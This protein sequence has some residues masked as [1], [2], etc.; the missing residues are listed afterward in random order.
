LVEQAKK[1]QA[2]LL[3]MVAPSVEKLVQAS[4]GQPVPSSA[5][6]K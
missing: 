5:P 2:Q 3:I 6:A 1:A 4:A